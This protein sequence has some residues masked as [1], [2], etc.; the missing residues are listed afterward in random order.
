VFD[1]R[2]RPGR[3]FETRQTFSNHH[4]KILERT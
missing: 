1:P 3:H 4:Q 2:A